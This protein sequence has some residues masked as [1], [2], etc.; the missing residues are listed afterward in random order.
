MPITIFQHWSTG[1]PGRVGLTFRDHGFKLDIRTPHIENAADLNKGVPVDLDD[2]E[3]LIILGGPQNVT[4]IDSHPWMQAEAEFIRQMH[5]AQR[6]I[7]GICLGAQLIAHALGGAVAPREKPAIGFHPLGLTPAGQTEP[8]LAGV[9]WTSPQLFSCGQEIKQLPPGGTLL[10]GT[11]AIPVQAFKAGLRTY[12]FV[13]HFECD[14]PMAEQLVE[15][16]VEFTAPAETTVGD[17]LAT[18]DRHYETYARL[19]DRLCVNL[20]TLLFPRGL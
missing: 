19:S 20:V 7:I 5:A 14:R 10:S 16:S 2:V 12:G 17:V 1:R 18:F 4:D 3:G 15:Q 11:K 13:F 8:M 6:P 9:Q